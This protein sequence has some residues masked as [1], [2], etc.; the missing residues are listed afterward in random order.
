MSRSKLTKLF[1]DNNLPI[2]KSTK[3]NKAKIN[4]TIF[5]SLN[6]ES[7]YWL[8]FIYADSYIEEKTYSFSI[9]LGAKDIEHL[10]KLASFLGYNKD[11][12]YR[13]DRNTYYIRFSDKILIRSLMKYGLTQKK[14]LTCV[15]PD[16]ST[17]YINEFIS[18]YFDGDG[19]VYYV[20]KNNS[21]LN[22]LGTLS[23]LN[24]INSNIDNICKI[25]KVKNSDIYRLELFGNN[26]VNMFYNNIYSSSNEYCLGRKLD[27]FKF[28]QTRSS[29]TKLPLSY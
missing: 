1:R 29:T 14:S 20:G 10:K 24:S 22:I 12:K 28:I 18:G 2:Q 16:I 13:E 11:I 17:E 6:N 4:N 19:S 3:S 9:E 26:K 27:K 23:F 8:G 21:G 25:R 15:F 5:E 7:A